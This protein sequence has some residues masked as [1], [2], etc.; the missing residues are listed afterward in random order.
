MGKKI[1]QTSDIGA[2]LKLVLGT[3]SGIDLGTKIGAALGPAFGSRLGSGPGLMLDIGFG[4]LIEEKL[5]GLEG[6]G[7]AGGGA[8]T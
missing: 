2:G 4:T 8:G 1:N 3:E 7:C 6:G 5:N